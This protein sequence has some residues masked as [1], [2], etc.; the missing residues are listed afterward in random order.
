M[1]NG[2][3]DGRLCSCRLSQWY[4]EGMKFANEPLSQICFKDHKNFNNE[5]EDVND[6]DASRTKILIPYILPTA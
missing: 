2:I 6:G 3:K 1:G 5:D 4:K